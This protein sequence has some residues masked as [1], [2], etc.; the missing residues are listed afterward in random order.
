MLK[1]LR[2]D[3][4]VVCVPGIFFGRVGERPESKGEGIPRIECNRSSEVFNG[5]IIFVLVEP[6]VSATA[7]RFRVGRVE[8]M[9]RL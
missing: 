2:F 6:G 1:L 7:E 8:A 9:A 4:I 3:V 5:P